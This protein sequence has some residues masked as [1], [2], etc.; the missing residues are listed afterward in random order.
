MKFFIALSSLVLLLHFP[1]AGQGLQEEIKSLLDQQADAWNDGDIERF[2]ETYW[3]SDKLQ[4]LNIEGPTYGWTST[5]V[6]YHRRYPDRQSMGTL[7]FG[8]EH[9]VKHSSRSATL[10]GSYH[11]ERSGMENKDGLF[12]VVLQKMKGRWRIVADSTH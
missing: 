6:N 11:L 5:L 4:F 9:L 2:M 10:I 7:K 12:L 1:L 3:Q 8:I